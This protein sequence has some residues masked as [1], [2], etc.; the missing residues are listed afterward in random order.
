MESRETRASL[1]SRVRDPSDDAAWREFDETYRDL[2]VRYC[3]ARGLQT[4]DAEDVRQLV[5]IGLAKALRS[6][7][8]QPQRG[9]FRHYLCRTI[10]NAITQ[11]QARPKHA[12]KPLDINELGLAAE[13]DSEDS[14]AIWEQEWMDHHYRMAMKTIRESFEPQ[15]IQVFDGLLAGRAV[16]DVARE[17]GTTAQAVHKIKQRIRN[18]M[19]E[20]VEE[21]IRSEDEPL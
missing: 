15:S 19:M 20:L 3:R 14:D 4:A 11:N 17:F 5:M 18:R 13:P 2:I 10:R 6:F 21:Q 12:A 8:Y 7:E 1:L 16:D 9:R